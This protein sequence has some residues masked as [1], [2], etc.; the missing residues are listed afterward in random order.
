MIAFFYHL[1]FII[2]SYK[3][4]KYFYSAFYFYGHYNEIGFLYVSHI[5]HISKLIIK[6][7]KI[8]NHLY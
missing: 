7:S 4:N 6:L 8:K 3:I 2:K 5:C 1:L